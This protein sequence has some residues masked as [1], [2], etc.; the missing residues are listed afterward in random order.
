MQ[1]TCGDKSVYRLA[2]RATGLNVEQL[3]GTKIA[4]VLNFVST[5]QPLMRPEALTITLASVLLSACI[6]TETPTLGAALTSEDDHRSAVVRLLSDFS[7]PVDLT[8]R[9]VHAAPITTTT[10]TV[11]QAEQ[12]IGS[13][14]ATLVGSS[15][16]EL[17]QSNP[18]I[19]NCTE[20]QE[21]FFQYGSTETSN[22]TDFEGATLLNLGQGDYQIT[23]ESWQTDAD[24]GCGWSGSETLN[25]GNSYL[26][27]TLVR[28]CQ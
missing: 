24:P 23:V 4:T 27:I 21:L 14:T 22:I 6:G 15:C 19:S 8:N 17:R 11:A 3:T 26:E 20:S 10:R 7:I 13:V 9:L 2:E 5:R 28:F 18:T 16:N 1:Q 25:A 12:S